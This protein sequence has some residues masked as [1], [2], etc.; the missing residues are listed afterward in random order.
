M[1][2]KLRHTIYACIVPEADHE[3][4]QFFSEGQGG[5]GGE[6]QELSMGKMD[7]DLLHTPFNSTNPSR[8]ELAL[9]AHWSFLD[10]GHHKTGV[11]Q[12]LPTFRER[13]QKWLRR[14]GKSR[15]AEE[16]EDDSLM[17]VGGGDK[18]ILEADT[19]CRAKD[20]MHWR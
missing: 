13:M 3:R 2:T 7:A 4:I 1:H 14:I 5:K 9:L 17:L 20:F 11:P 8:G 16:Q 15:Q 12:D 10:K 18:S 19:H 6:P